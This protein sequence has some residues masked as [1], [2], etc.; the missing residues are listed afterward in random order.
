MDSFFTKLDVAILGGDQRELY[1]ARELSFLGANVKL[2]GHSKEHG[3]EGIKVVETVADALK[4]AKVAIAP[5]PGTDQEGKIV[6]PFSSNPLYLDHQSIAGMQNGGL[7]LIGIARPIIKSLCH[8]NKLKLIEL[9]E[10]DEIAVPNAVLT[11][12]GAIQLTMEKLPITIDRCQA[13]VLGFGR[14]G[15]SMNRILRALNADTR[16]VARKL[17]ALARAEEM[18]AKTYTFDNL[19]IALKGVEVIYN[20]IPHL[21]LSRDILSILPKDIL[22][23]DLASTPGGVDFEAAKELGLDA[24][25]APGLPGKVAP[26]TAGQILAKHVP[27]IIIRELYFV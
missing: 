14:V 7:F 25:L 23:I 11:A 10:L 27:Q 26:K 6:A 5:M 21:I 20:T 12:E 8:A 15:F 1:L 16:V 18:G 9:A 2:V 24:F 22:I 4:G 13:A 17:S 3:Q 19:S